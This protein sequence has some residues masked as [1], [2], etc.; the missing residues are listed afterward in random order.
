MLIH[1][2]LKAYMTSNGTQKTRSNGWNGDEVGS[3]MVEM[4]P[5]IKKK[6]PKIHWLKYE[7]KGL[8]YKKAIS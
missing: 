7:I 1:A 8:K 6:K 2:R 3:D 5:E 4:T